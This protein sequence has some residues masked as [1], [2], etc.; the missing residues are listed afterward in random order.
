[1][2]VTCPNCAH[3]FEKSETIAVKDYHDDFEPLLTSP[4]KRV[5]NTALTACDFMTLFCPVCKTEE[6]VALEQ[7]ISMSKYGTLLSHDD[8]AELWPA[9]VSHEVKIHTRHVH[10]LSGFISVSL[11]TALVAGGDTD[12]VIQQLIDKRLRVLAHIFNI[13]VA[14][15]WI[16]YGVLAGP[17]VVNMAVLDP[18]LRKLIGLYVGTHVPIDESKLEVVAGRD[19]QTQIRLAEQKWLNDRIGA[20]LFLQEGEL[21]TETDWVR[22]AELHNIA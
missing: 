21:G 3:D 19:R 6:P 16:K 10:F 5:F 12:G 4:A 1:M 8:V 14:E 13:G 20:P 18:S 7:Q 15:G 2:I 11:A 22:Y 17:M 9:H